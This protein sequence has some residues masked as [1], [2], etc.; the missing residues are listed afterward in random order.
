MDN[1]QCQSIK[2][3]T[4]LLMISLSGL[5]G[6]SSLDNMRALNSNTTSTALNAGDIADYAA[7]QEAVY[8][9]LLS[10]A[11]L[12]GQPAT[13]DEWGQVIMAGVQ[14]SNQKCENYLEAVDWAKQGRQRDS[15]L[16]GQ[17]GTFTNGVMGITDASARDL[18][19]TAAAFG[20]TSVGFNTLNQ[21]PLAGLEASAVRSVVHTAQQ[22]YVKDLDF[23]QYTNRI[24]AFNA[25]QGYIRLCMPGNIAAEANQAV[26]NTK[27]VDSTTVDALAVPAIPF[28]PPQ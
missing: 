15:N 10:L 6:C 17:V 9:A 2:R 20:A 12:P 13:T 1:K 18:A 19:L 21:D 8:Q 11:G 16:L 23:N 5:A 3:I 26:R 25:L 22:Q 14:Y 7:N 27:T 24:S 28:M 4:G